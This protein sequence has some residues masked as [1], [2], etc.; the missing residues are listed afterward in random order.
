MAIKQKALISFSQM[1]DEKFLVTSQTILAAMSNNPHYTEPS[2]SPAVIIP[3]VDDFSALLSAARKRGAPEDTA[4]KNESRLLLEEELKLLGYYVNTVAKGQLSVLLSS[5]F[6]IS[7]KPAPNM[8]PLA[9]EMVRLKDG[10]QSGQV[11]LDFINQKHALLYEYR[12]RT[13]SEEQSEWSDRYS[14]TSSRLNIIA[15]LEIGTFCEVQ[16]RAV[17][18]QGPGDW[19]Q[20]VTILVR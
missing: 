4:L 13:K 8:V 1:K 19:S 10:R 18:S 12:F 17:N 16:V 14:T 11:Q 15:P 20:T 7:T 6:P 5:G 3:L 9:V 2:P